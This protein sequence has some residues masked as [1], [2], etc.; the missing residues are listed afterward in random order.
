MSIPKAFGIKQDFG[1]LEVG[2]LGFF[3]LSLTAYSQN[4]LR[5]PWQITLKN[6]FIKIFQLRSE[7]IRQS[8]A[9]VSTKWVIPFF[10]D[11]T[12][13]VTCKFSRTGS[14][15]IHYLSKESNSWATQ[16]TDIS[17]MTHMDSFTGLQELLLEH[18]YFSS[19]TIGCFLC[20][21]HYGLLCGFTRN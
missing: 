13:E 7:I 12:L 11:L 5:S 8:F 14:I 6:N 10:S 1:K 21:V 4:I 15:Q 3:D 16:S 17:S 9:F 18:N 20:L 19:T 2:L